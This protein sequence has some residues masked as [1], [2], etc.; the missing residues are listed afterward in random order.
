M[1]TP[2]LGGMVK[3]NLILAVI[4]GF[5]V[6]AETYGETLRYEGFIAG[7]RAGEATVEL[8]ISADSYVISGVAATNGLLDIFG[9]WRASFDAHGQIVDARPQI[10]EFHYVEQDDE[11]QREVTVRDG[12]L[13]VFK[14]GKP[15]SRRSALPGVDLLTTLFVLP[16]C[17]EEKL[18]HT[19]RQNYRLRRIESPAEAFLAGLCRYDVV[20]DE[21]IRFQVS[22]EFARVA[23]LTIPVKMTFEGLLT[24]WLE[25]VAPEVVD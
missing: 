7:V 16:Q 4:L 14:N 5:A 25:L 2:R 8:E 13:L 1:R 3:L 22:I 24:G 17:E 12:V 20:D 9:N 6:S 10:T 21:G 19:G 18:L 23:D 11:K 15:R